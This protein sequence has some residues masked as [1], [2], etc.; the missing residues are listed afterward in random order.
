MLLDCRWRDI[1]AR[2]FEQFR[3]K[4]SS[5]AVYLILGGLSFVFAINFGPGSGSCSP[6]PDSYAARVDG[7]VIRQQDFAVMYRQRVEQMRRI[8]GGSGLEL[9]DEMLQKMGLRRQVLDGMIDRKILAAEARGRGITVSDDELT[10]FLIKNF[11]LEEITAQEWE[12]YVNNVY[13]MAAWQFEEDVRE[14]LMGQKL[15]EILESNVEVASSELRSE[16]EKEF[17]RA[18]VSYVRFG[19]N[20]GDIAQPTEAEATAW[21]SAN[22]EA[23]QKAYEADL[24]SY[25]VGK[26]VEAIQILKRVARDADEAALEKAK[27]ELLAVK[28]RIDAG[29]D[30]A[31]LAAELSED[32]NQG[33]LG[34]FARG[35][36]ART[37][38]DAAFALAAGEMSKGPVQS[39]QGWHLVKVVNVIEPSTKAFDDVKGEVALKV[40]VEERRDAAA[41]A[42]AD[43]FLAKAQAAE[44]GMLSLTK[45]KAELEAEPQEG[46]L[47][48]ETTPWVLK[49]GSSISGIGSSDELHALIFELTEA[50]PLASKPVRVGQA[51]FVVE[52]LNREEPTD[53]G[54]EERKDTLRDQALSSKR[55]RVVE[56]WLK[57]A[58]D[59]AT[60]EVNPLVLASGN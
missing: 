54:F 14:Q 25:Q 55:Q 23:A 8:Y 36:L 45:T 1:P 34:T 19:L 16:Y 50:A 38:E 44:G 58:R 35:T 39:R 33:K 43:A 17:N 12:N 24:S 28:A 30:F 10:A 51:Y 13:R 48:R 15:V 20:S 53:S 4:S 59:A 46:M 60:V 29:E 31:A 49:S 26:Q 6:G 52:H 7:E 11:G 3:K 21:L 42:S 18:M 9:S 22:T 57:S 56:D 2:M 41:K 27:S 40:L 32:G 47:V 37:L 5:L